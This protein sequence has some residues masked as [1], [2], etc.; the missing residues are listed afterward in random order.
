V[1][2]VG[3]PERGDDAAGRAVARLLMRSPPRDVEVMEE[4]GEATRLLAR[5]EKADAVFII[6]ACASGAVAGTVRRF[7]A[8][9]QPLPKAAFGFSTHGFGLADA[10][11]LARSLNALPSSC[12]VYAIEGES[13]DIGAPMSPAVAAAIDVVAERLRTEIAGWRY[14]EEDPNA[15]SLSDGEPD[16]PDR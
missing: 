7:E 11:E 10:V 2:G 4:D 9:A 12:V 8:A 3:N 1:I 16:A 14:L 6:D 15:R 5:F 13:F